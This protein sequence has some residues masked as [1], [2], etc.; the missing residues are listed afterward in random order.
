MRKSVKHPLLWRIL[1]GFGVLLLAVLLVVHTYLAGWLLDYVNGVLANIKG[2]QSSVESINIDLY[3][4]AY[5]IN[6]IVINKKEG[7]I[8]TPF[9]AIDVLDF[10]LQWSALLHG[11]IV[12]DMKLIH[13]VINFAVNESATQNGM[14]VDWTKPIKDLMPIDINHVHFDDGSITYKD[15]S[16]T[17]PVNIYIHHMY[18]EVD[19]LRNVE[20]AA[21]SLPSPMEVQGSSIGNGNLKMRGRLNIIKQIPDMDV[22]LAL[23]NVA[24][25][26]L[27]SYSEAYAAFDFKSGTFNL[28]S[29]IIVKND[30]VSGYVK[31]MA[32]N[33]SVDVLKE[34]NPLRIVWNTAVAA[35]LKIFTNPTKDQFAT[36]ADLEGNLDNV[37]ANTWTVL[38]GIVRNAFIS[39]MSKGFEQTD[40]HDVIK[41]PE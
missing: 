32:T 7:N 34:P 4:S 41:K 39:A 31:P 36:R 10:S 22:Q 19:N 12:S 24:L 9:I 33:L 17:P 38:G 23:E 20:S 18:G 6:K 14:G 15:F 26:A 21:E 5:R 29:Q 27:N 35:I 8:P 13:P 16:S 40:R 28:Y 25:P 37:N 2:Y 1:A 11:R 3:R 30:Q